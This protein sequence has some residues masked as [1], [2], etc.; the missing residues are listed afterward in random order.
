MTDRKKEEPDSRGAA[1]FAYRDFRLYQMAR[2]LVIMGA[3]AQSVAG[4]WQVYL[5]T[6]RAIDLGYT[7]LA[8]FL[9]GLLFLLP[10]GHVADRFDRRQVILVCYSIQVF[11]TLGLLVFTRVA[12]TSVFPIYVVLFF[13]GTA[14][15][16][17]GP[18]SSALIPHLVPEHHFVNAVTWG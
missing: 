3:E 9:P 14:R 2:A 7:G 11:C 13:I 10:A 4:A 15:A 17:S 8:L 18:A 6:H 12:V 16:F 5:I 1:A